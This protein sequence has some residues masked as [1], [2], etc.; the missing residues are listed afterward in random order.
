VPAG[1]LDAVIAAVQTAAIDSLDLSS[2][3]FPEAVASIFRF[4]LTG[5]LTV[6]YPQH[7]RSFLFI[8]GR[9]RAVR[10]DCEEERLGSWLV[11]RELMTVAELTRALEQRSQHEVPLIEQLLST[12]VVDRA[13]LEKELARRAWHIATRAASEHETELCFCDGHQGCLPLDAF[14]GNGTAQ[15]TLELARARASTVSEQGVV[16]QELVLPNQDIDDLRNEYQLTPCEAFLLS[17]LTRGRSVADL[18]HHCGLPGADAEQA[19]GALHMAGLV[20]FETA[21]RKGTARGTGSAA[22]DELP[23]DLWEERQQLIEL[24]KRTPLLDHYQALG[25]VSTA[26]TRAIT[27]AWEQCSKLYDPDRVAEP[28]LH[29]LERTLDLLL[30]RAKAAFEVLC[31]EQL[32]SRYDK[33]REGVLAQ[34]EHQPPDELQHSARRALVTAN[35]RRADQLLEIGEQHLAIVLLETAASIQPEA[36]TYLRLAR[37]LRTRST[38]T[39]RALQALREAVVI[40]PNCVEAWLEL[41]SIWGHRANRDRQ[42]RSLKRALAIDPDNATTR[43]AYTQALGTAEL[44]QELSRLGTARSAPRPSSSPAE[45]LWSNRAC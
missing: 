42:H 26:D 32:R 10:S 5:T 9:L 40:E 34:A 36:A 15:L 12:G 38:T 2:T 3:S 22:A 33:V 21:P 19:L 20:R 18:I 24:A 44:E 39:K 8:D 4:R 14:A 43:Q 28:H 11:R 7:S 35:L 13:R 41:A 27:T 45:H 30:Q 37:I 1:S 6:F 25:V 29:D 16:P 23:H 17:R 31:S